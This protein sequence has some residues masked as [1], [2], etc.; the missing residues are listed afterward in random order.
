MTIF[1]DIRKKTTIINNRPLKQDF[2][3]KIRKCENCNET[4]EWFYF[5]YYLDQYLT[6]K[7]DILYLCK[8]CKIK[9]K[10]FKNT[11]I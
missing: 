8:S 1:D 5:E 4:A 3:E 2:Y 7:Y 6:V 9:H 10:D 11:N